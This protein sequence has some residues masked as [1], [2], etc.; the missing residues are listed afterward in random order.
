MARKA[1]PERRERRGGAVFRA[2]CQHMIAAELQRRAA[3][4]RAEGRA[5]AQ[6]TPASQAQ[7]PR[8]G[9]AGA[10]GRDGVAKRTG[11]SGTISRAMTRRKISSG[12]SARARNIGVVK[13]RLP[14]GRKARGE[15]GGCAPRAPPRRGRRAV[16]DAEGT[17]RL[18]PS[19]ASRPSARAAWCGRRRDRDWRDRS[20][21][22]C[23]FA[24][25]QAIN[26]V[27]LQ[28][29]KGR[30][31]ISP[32]RATG[33]RH[34]GKSAGAAAA[35]QAKQDGFRLI[36]GVMGRCDDIRADSRGVREE[37]FI[38][39]VPRQLLDFRFRLIPGPDEDIVRKPQPMRPF[40]DLFGLR[41]APRGAD[42]D[43][44]SRH[45]EAAARISLASTPR[46]AASGRP[47]PGRRRRRGEFFA[48]PP[49]AGKAARPGPA[50]T[51]GAPA[52]PWPRRSR[53]PQ[54]A[55]PS[56]RSALDA[57]GLPVRFGFDARRG[58]R[59]F[60][61]NFGECRA[62]LFLGSERVERLT[63]PQHGVG[64]AAGTRVLR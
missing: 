56:P 23:A 16:R 9:R 51:P 3:E 6:R 1:S 46:R 61:R 55:F 10:A 21:K 15:V 60:A 27:L 37:E 35:Q 49:K 28:C 64:R 20:K 38:T 13:P 26:S 7:A 50:R 39:G 31:W 48:R 53:S 25:Q 30:A 43:R 52:D 58:I 19:F 33:R 54:A 59:I 34:A 8:A 11:E 17:S 22:A 36:V 40:G 47:N 57:F 4:R 41:A 2:N 24:A 14:R 42:H 18:S 5:R 29:N 12:A 32:R 45:E 44:R 63:E 62:G